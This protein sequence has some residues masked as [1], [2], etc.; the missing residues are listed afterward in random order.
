MLGY[1]KLLDN[2]TIK[3]PRYLPP[4]LVT[5][6]SP[7]RSGTKAQDKGLSRSPQHRLQNWCKPDDAD[8]NQGDFADLS[9]TNCQSVASEH[10]DSDAFEIVKPAEE[11]FDVV[12]SEKKFRKKKRKRKKK[13]VGADTKR[14]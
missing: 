4:I 9:F 13:V 2:K 11:V 3:I 8:S 14:T 12:T 5:S 7:V 6:A 1:V 10:T